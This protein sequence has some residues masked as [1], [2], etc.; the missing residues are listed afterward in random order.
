[1]DIL[2]IFKSDFSLRSRSILTVDEAKEIDNDNPISIVSIAKTH[3]ISQP[4]FVCE[5]RLLSFFKCYKYFK[6]INIDFIYGLRLTIVNDINNKT[7]ESLSEESKI[8]LLLSNVN[9]YSNFLKIY[10]KS[11]C[12]GKYYGPRCS[13]GLLK[14]FWCDSLTLCLPFYD[15][16]IHTNLLANSSIVPQ[17]P[18]RPVFFIEEHGLPFDNLIKEATESYALSNGYETQKTHSI[19]YYKSS[20]IVPYQVFRTMHEGSTMA[21]PGLDHFATDTFSFEEYLRLTGKSL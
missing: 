8:V 5:D 13:W 20:D 21:M 19:Y 18:A 3:Q 6:E 15:S 7:K 17:F 2:P 12:D 16:F 10:T 9:G 4:V 14:E 1:M 11:A